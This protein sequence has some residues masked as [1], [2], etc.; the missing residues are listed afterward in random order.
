MARWD[1]KRG[2]SRRGG[3]GHGGGADV[4]SEAI[5]VF[6]VFRESVTTSLGQPLSRQKNCCLRRAD[7]K[8]DEYVEIGEMGTDG[9]SEELIVWSA[10]VETN[11]GPP[12]GSRHRIHRLQVPALR[13]PG[14]IPRKRCAYPS[15][16][17]YVFWRFCC[18]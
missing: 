4:E 3:E 18:S 9:L 1:W 13:A 11:G 6:I 15:G 8:I 17:P 12:A 10:S 16:M 5:G 14:L 2:P 7:G